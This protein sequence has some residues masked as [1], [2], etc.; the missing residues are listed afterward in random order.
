MN[1]EKALEAVEFGVGEIPVEIDVGHV[2]PVQLI[3]ELERAGHR[4]RLHVTAAAVGH[5][6]ED[7]DPRILEIAVR[8]RIAGVE[9]SEE[10]TSELQ[11]LMR[12]SYAVF[13][14]TQ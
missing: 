2:E 1:D 14:L 13:C 10:H 6:R 3:I 5:V 4:C 11:S 9:R 7:V 12:H 8:R